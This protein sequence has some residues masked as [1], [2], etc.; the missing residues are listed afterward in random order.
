MKIALGKGLNSLI[1]PREDKGAEVLNVLNEHA[2]IHEI[3][4][5]NI[6]P[7][8]FQPRQNFAED[9][10][11]ELISSIKEQGL[12]QPIIVKKSSGGKYDLIAGER[13]YRAVKALGMAKIP[14]IIKD[15]SD[16]K[17]LE[18][19]LIENI[20]REDLNS[21]EEAEAYERL[22]T[23]FNLTQEEVGKKVGKDRAT[24][25]N[26]IRLLKLP[27]PIKK[28]IT[29]NKLS[30]GHGRTLLAI[31]FKEKQIALA[32]EIIKK[33]LSVRQTEDLIKAH[34]GTKPPI[35]NEE[36]QKKDIE[37]IDLENNLKRFFGTNVKIKT[38]GKKGSIVIDYFSLDE[39][40]RIL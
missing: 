9:K 35:L 7:Q 14:A 4:V 1:P 13:R 16:E 37:I 25:T 5:D 22:L 8:K 15:V 26:T 27:D 17:M 12:I 20:Q 34:L 29:E 28:M 30:S 6:I 21:I 40:N 19:A 3:M 32:N 36:K 38:K 31:H 24:I 33:D 10:L 23:Q 39:L 18:L 11:Q 2:V